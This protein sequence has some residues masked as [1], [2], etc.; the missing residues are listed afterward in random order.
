MQQ[1]QRF[2]EERRAAFKPVRSWIQAKQRSSID[3]TSAPKSLRRA[4][5]WCKSPAWM[6]SHCLHEAY[7][8]TSGMCRALSDPQVSL[9]AEADLLGL[10]SN[11]Q[12]H[13]A[14]P[15]RKTST[16]DFTLRRSTSLPGFGAI[17]SVTFS[18][19]SELTRP[20]NWC[21]ADSGSSFRNLPWATCSSR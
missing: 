11:L 2:A 4:F 5:K 16:A 3:K 6:R 9:A 20:M 19:V 15:R 7:G 17:P 10:N 8:Q 13:G 14:Y 18:I 21:A 1:P 12:G